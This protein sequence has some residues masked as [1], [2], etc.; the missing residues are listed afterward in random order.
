MKL[1]LQEIRQWWSK[2]Q[3][4]KR[5]AFWI[6]MGAV[7]LT[8]YF[9]F[10]QAGWV[11]GGTALRM[12]ERSSD[13]ILVSRLAEICVAQFTQDPDRDQKLAEMMERSTITQRAIFVRD[14]GWATMPGDTEPDEWCCQSMC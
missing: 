2:A 6:A 14:Q 10:T 5:A 3:P 8:I 4:T 9:G 13:D 7:L 12:A 1:K 11:T